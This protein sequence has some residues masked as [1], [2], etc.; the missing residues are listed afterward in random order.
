M[1]STMGK[2]YYCEYC[3]RHFAD[4]P[5]NR[6]KHIKGIQHCR[7]RKMHYDSFKGNIKLMVLYISTNKLIPVQRRT[8]VR[9][10]GNNQIMALKVSTTL[11]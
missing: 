6:K 10:G 4:S 1:L 2:R 8:K 9:G 5:G 11:T 3:D 7:N